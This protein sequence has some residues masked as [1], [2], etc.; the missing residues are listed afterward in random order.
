MPGALNLPFADVFQHGL[1][2]PKAELREMIAPLLDDRERSI[3]SC[4]SG[5]TACVTAFAAHYSGYD[6][7]AI[8]D[9]SWC[10]WGQPGELPVVTD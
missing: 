4:G 10:E 8:Y 3:H 6:G 9:G 1:L 7:L 2:K 5:V